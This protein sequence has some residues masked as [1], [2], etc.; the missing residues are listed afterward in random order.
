MEMQFINNVKK[1]NQLI[2]ENLNVL[3]RLLHEPKTEK[4]SIIQAFSNILSS[5]IELREYLK[6]KFP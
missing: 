3:E 1:I 5:M 4:A 6:T 2:V